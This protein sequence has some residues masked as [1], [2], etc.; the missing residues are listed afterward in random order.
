MSTYH[1]AVWIDHHEA[2]IFQLRLDGS[3]EATL[4]AQTHHIHRHPMGA[5]DKHNHPDDMHHFFR[6]VAKA[7]DGAHEI[8]IGGPSSAKTELVSYVHQ[9]DPALEKKIVRVETIDHPTDAQLVAHARQFFKLEKP[10]V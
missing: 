9:H 7:L 6:D 1:A 10:R 4:H 8:L 3:D 5:T 2:R